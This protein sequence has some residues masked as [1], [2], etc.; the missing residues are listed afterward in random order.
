MEM[1]IETALRHLRLRIAL[2]GDGEVELHEEGEIEATVVIPG[3]STVSF[4]RDGEAVLKAM[5]GKRLG[6]GPMGNAAFFA[7][8]M[9]NC[10]V[11]MSRGYGSGSVEIAAFAD[12]V[13]DADDKDVEAAII[14]S[15]PKEID[16]A[17]DFFPMLSHPAVKAAGESADPDVRSAYHA[18]RVSRR[19][20]S[21]EVWNEMDSL[22]S[23]SGRIARLTR[24]KEPLPSTN[25]RWERIESECGRIEAARALGRLE[26]GLGSF[27]GDRQLYALRAAGAPG[28]KDGAIAAVAVF[29]QGELAGVV[30]HADISRRPPI[31][32]AG[33]LAVVIE[34]VEKV[35]Q[36]RD[37]TAL[38]GM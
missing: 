3:G 36:A 13:V 34:A 21:Q 5:N 11:M 6:A 26:G 2:S 23:W 14:S 33:D 15:A 8:L 31:R 12:A 32:I 24:T 28:I 38:F 27:T 9:H 29:E 25:G 19:S 10:D 4:G 20:P 22:V 37:R 18:W 7:S 1:G 16:G 30:R 17:I 35:E